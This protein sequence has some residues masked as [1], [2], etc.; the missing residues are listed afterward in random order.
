MLRLLTPPVRRAC[1]RAIAGSFLLATGA[2]CSGDGLS[3]SAE[4]ALPVDS[5]AVPSDTTVSAP[6]DSLAPAPTDSAAPPTDSTLPVP[7]PT[8]PPPAD[9]VVIT[10][11]IISTSPQPGIAFG[12]FNMEG[13]QLGTV[14]T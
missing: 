4:A 7:D 8:V 10:E 3:P 14:H 9:S 13:P 12:T 5:T 2:A 6:S 1:L 11:V